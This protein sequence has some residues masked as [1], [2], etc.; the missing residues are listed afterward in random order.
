MI[1][2][3][4][5]EEADEVDEEDV[6]CVEVDVLEGTVDVEAGAVTTVVDVNDCELDEA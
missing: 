4:E 5:V 2:A 3:T 1:S 6:G